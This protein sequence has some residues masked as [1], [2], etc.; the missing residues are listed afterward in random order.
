MYIGLRDTFKEGRYAWVD[1]LAFGP[2]S[3]VPIN[4]GGGNLENC[5][6]W[7]TKKP[8]GCWSDRACTE[9]LPFTC[10]KPVEGV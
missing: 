7:S 9:K 4:A 10:R 6:A 1:G 2:R 5:V 8:V 3:C